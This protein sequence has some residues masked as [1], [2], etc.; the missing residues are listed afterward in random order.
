LGPQFG[1]ELFNF[2]SSNWVE[3]GTWFV[4]QYNFR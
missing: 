3:S 1:D 4:H 2:G